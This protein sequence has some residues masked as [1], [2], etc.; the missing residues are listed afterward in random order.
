M[1]AQTAPA[2]EASAAD[3]EAENNRAGRMRVLEARAFRGPSTYAHRR[4]IRMTLDFGEPQDYPTS[5]LRDFTDRLIETI[6]T[7]DEHTCSYGVPGGFV[8][9]LREGTWLGHVTEHI[10]I[11]LQCLAG[12][13][14]S[15]GK[16][17]GTGDDGVY[18]VVHSYGEERIGFLAAH[19]ALRLAQPR[20]LVVIFADLIND[21]WQQITA[22]NGHAS[23]SP[24]NQ[25]R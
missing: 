1:S 15:Y 10:A 7:L 25:S 11:E 6:P 18:Y 20:D 21:V 2:A 12:T 13:R 5:K 9:R 3:R 19:L 8:Q 4:V 24:S 23:S 17:R 22:F 14:V 16:T